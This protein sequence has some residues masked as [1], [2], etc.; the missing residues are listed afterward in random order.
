MILRNCRFLVITLVGLSLSTSFA[1]GNKVISEAMKKYHKGP[2]GTEP[3]AKKISN[4]TASSQEIADLL[5][6]YQQIAKEDPPKGDKA[7]WEKKTGA[8]IDALTL[9]EK[10]DPK[11]LTAYKLSINCK[12]C[13]TEH[14][15]AKPQ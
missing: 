2:E 10:K 5:K 13:H 12:A 9:I 15:P 8:V 6:A 7:D 3:V 14:R 1:A 4:G 11:G